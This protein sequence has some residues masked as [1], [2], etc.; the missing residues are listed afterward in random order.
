MATIG[1]EPHKKRALL[2]YFAWSPV[3]QCL[4]RMAPATVPQFL[5]LGVN[6]N[7]STCV[8]PSISQR[9]WEKGG[10]R[11]RSVPQQKVEQQKIHS[12]RGRF[13][14]IPPMRLCQINHGSSSARPL[15]YVCEHL[16]ICIRS[17]GLDHTIARGDADARGGAA[18]SDRGGGG[19]DGERAIFC[20]PAP[21]VALR[22]KSRRKCTVEGGGIIAL[23]QLL[24]EDSGCQLGTSA[25]KTNVLIGQISPCRG[26][27]TCGSRRDEVAVAAV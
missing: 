10:W 5:M 15:V 8:L 20:A 11:R 16:G 19:G 25:R 13:V 27:K 23:C 6:T 22:G 3:W 2:R 14:L 4:G 26:T 1:N 12:I 24:P 9:L 21:H 7:G 17:S 18:G